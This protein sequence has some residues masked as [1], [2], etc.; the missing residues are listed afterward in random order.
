MENVDEAPAG[1]QPGLPADGSLHESIRVQL[2]LHQ[3]ICLSGA[4]QSSGFHAGLFL[5]SRF[6]QGKAGNVP[7]QMRSFRLDHVLLTDEDGDH[8]IRFGRILGRLHGQWRTGAG[9]SHARAAEI[10][11]HLDECLRRLWFNGA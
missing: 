9:D 4:A 2:A 11:T 5:A 10:L 1:A 7:A 8:Q 6:M 3:D